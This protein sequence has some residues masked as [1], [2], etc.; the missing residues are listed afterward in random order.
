MPSALSDF[1]RSARLATGLR[2]GELALRAGWKDGSIGGS[3][4]ARFERDGDAIASDAQIARIAKAL[5]LTPEEAFAHESA[6]RTQARTEWNA[7]VDEPVERSMV[8]RLLPAVW[9]GREIPTE[10]TT[11]EEVIAWAT[12]LE[13]W[14]H[15]LKCLQWSRRHATYIRPDGSHYHCEG[16]FNED[17]PGPWMGIR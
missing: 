1:L 12:E 14:K 6:E 13:P 16:G 8:I 3:W 4:I 5:G 11:R 7:W 9:G 17:G 10:L 2:P 15:A